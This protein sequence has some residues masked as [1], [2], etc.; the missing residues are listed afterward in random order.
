MARPPPAAPC[1]PLDRLWR[2]GAAD[3]GGAG[4]RHRQPAAADGRAKPGA[5]RRL[6]ERAGR[7]AGAL[8]QRAR[9]NGRGA[10]RASS[11]RACAWAPARTRWWSGARNCRSRC[12]PGLLPDHPLT[13]LQ[14]RDLVA[15][16]SCRT[17]IAA[18]AWSACPA[19]TRRSIRST[20]S[21]VSA[22][23][24]SSAR[25]FPSARRCSRCRRTCRAW[26]RAS[27]STRRACASACR[28]GRTPPTVRS[29]P[30]WTW[31]GAPA[32]ACCGWAGATCA[33]RTGMGSSPALGLVPSRGAPK[34]GVW[35]RC[36]IAASIASRCRPTCAKRAL[37]PV[38]PLQVGE[39]TR[40]LR[41]GARARATCSRAGMPPR[42]AGACRCRACR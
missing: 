32:A 22:N 10:G 27:G 37:R 21:R 40:A 31:T 42:P 17:P 36:T 33:W 25:A 4:G 23:C 2:A 3:R 5:D 16:R 18:G 26:T 28:A 8:H 7:R 6:A 11:S 30:C 29:T 12:I 9:R 15:R 41:V 35:A 38:A 1:A 13:E 34:L 20:G 39:T 19:R 14:I 24:G